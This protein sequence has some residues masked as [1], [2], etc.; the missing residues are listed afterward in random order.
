MRILIA[1]WV[2]VL[3][4]V[5]SVAGS[6][7]G[8]FGGRHRAANAS[9][10]E[11]SALDKAASAPPSPAPI[12]SASTAKTRVYKVHK[13]VKELPGHE[14]LSTPEGAYAAIHRAWAAEGDAAWA[15]LTVPELAVK[16]PEAAIKPL[17]KEVA[18][19]ALN[20]E[21][22]E[23][24]VW[25]DIHACVIAREKDGRGR[26]YFDLR[27]LNR[28]D[29]RWLNNGNDG[30]DTLERARQRIARILAGEAAKQMRDHRPPVAD[31]DAYLKPF[32][33]FLKREAKAPQRFVLDAIGKH[34]VVILSEVHNRPRYWAFNAALVR[35][36]E[37]ARRAGVI[38]MELPS[39]DQDLVDRFLAAAKLDPEPVIDML[40]DMMEAGWPDQATLEFFCTVW[41]VNQKLPQPQR[42]RIVLVDM[43]RPWKEIERREDWQK[44]DVDRDQC[45]A[46]NIVRDLKD[47]AADRRHALF[48][49]GYGHAMVNLTWAGGDPMRSAGWHLRKT[50]GAEN[51]FAIFPH[52]P[53][54]TNHGDVHGRIALGLFETAFAALGNKP[55]AFPLDRGPFG[56]QLFDA[57]FERLTLDPFAKGYH[58]YLYL[59]PVEGELLSPLIPG[60]YSDKFMGE[61]DR[62]WRIMYGKGLVEDG[63]VERLDGASYA[64]YRSQFWGQPRRGWSADYLGPLDA[65]KYGSNYKDVISKRLPSTQAKTGKVLEVYGLGRDTGL[66]LKSMVN[67]TS[68]AVIAPDPKRFHGDN[69]QGIAWLKE[70]GID[71]IAFAQSD[72]GDRGLAGYDM[73]AVKISNDKFDAMDRSG[74]KRTLEILAEEAD[75]TPTTMMSIKSGLPVTYAIRT[76]NG[77]YGVLQVEDARLTATPVVFRF[78]YKLFTK[79]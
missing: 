31:P 20:A 15:R 75:Q 70:K 65:W 46:E 71:L 42:L 22:L 50:L 43:A 68:G 29:G 18:E 1:K 37:F 55:V 38:Y 51:V 9:E 4:L 76:R 56:R 77:S 2:S 58:A 34:R 53:V 30:S 13:K 49:V 73:V 59:G 19:R 6:F 8:A 26:D 21:I 74:V 28:V 41:E 57:D 69:P 11:Q 14:D 7:L 35:S 12:G 60:F 48:L 61:M 44:Y 32:V 52:S 36:P 24:H 23:V 40:R 66:G 79:P 45:M 62:R 67:L 5:I 72:S 3:F 54:I 17:P 47:H 39:N 16:L 78:R 25:D 27:Y 33:D 64:A 10:G 63:V